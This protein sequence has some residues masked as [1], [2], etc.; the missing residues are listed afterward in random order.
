MD[1]R[2]ILIL[3]LLFGAASFIVFVI[4]MACLIISKFIG[5]V[6]HSENSGDEKPDS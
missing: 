4:F 3:F 1:A 5:S 6:D 2:V